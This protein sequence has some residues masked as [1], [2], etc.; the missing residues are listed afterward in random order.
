[1]D[2]ETFSSLLVFSFCQVSFFGNLSSLMKTKNKEMFNIGKAAAIAQATINTYTAA[3]A[4]F[5]AMAGI[6]P[7]PVWGIAAAASAVVAGM[8]NV[9]NIANTQFQAAEDG[10][11]IPAS[12]EGT[13]I[14][15]GEKNKQEMI[16]PFENEKAMSKLKGLGNT[17]INVYV[18]N[19]MADDTMPAKVA[20]KIDEALYNLKRKGQSVFA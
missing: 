9:N 3:T 19:L 16:I 2:N 17:T 7:A 11:I 10:G 14:K 1:V 4:A 18:E 12:A 13:L 5:K 20:K 6:P 15:A 8:V